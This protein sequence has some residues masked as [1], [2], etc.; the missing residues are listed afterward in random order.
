LADAI[1]RNDEVVGSIPTSS[2]KF[3]TTLV[4]SQTTNLFHSA[5]TKN[6]MLAGKTALT[7]FSTVEVVPRFGAKREP[8]EGGTVRELRE[9][10]RGSFMSPTGN[11]ARRVVRGLRPIGRVWIRLQETPSPKS[12][13][14]RRA[15][16]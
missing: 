11:R 8:L 13:T 3:S 12:A 5:P 1:V 16:Y 10:Y 14:S 7:V 15:L 4:E 6:S 2:T 9:L